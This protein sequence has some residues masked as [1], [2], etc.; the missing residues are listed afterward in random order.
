MKQE[1]THTVSSRTH[2]TL[3]WEHKVEAILNATITFPVHVTFKEMLVLHNFRRE[4]KSFCFGNIVR[5]SWFQFL[6]NHCFVDFLEFFMLEIISSFGSIYEYKS[7]IFYTS[8]Y[9]N[10]ESSCLSDKQFLS[11]KL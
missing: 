1:R 8:M 9:D 6:I 3:N 7:Y 4:L 10:I 5:N 11:K 2:V